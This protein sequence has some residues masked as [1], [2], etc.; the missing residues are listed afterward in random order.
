MLQDDFM[1]LPGPQLRRPYP[2]PLSAAVFVTVV[3]FIT[4]TLAASSVLAQVPGAMI[5]GDNVRGRVL[6]ANQQAASATLI[7]L[8]GGVA[9]EIPVGTGPHE[10]AISHDGHTGAISIYGIQPAGNQI[11]IIDMDKGVV[12]KTL[13]LGSYRRPHGMR[14]LPGDKT[15]LA[16]S[17]ASSKVLVI[18]IASGAIDTIP[19]NARGSHMMAMNDAGTVLF[20]ANVGSGSI[21][22]MDLKQHKLV[23]TYPIAQQTEGIS[24]SPDGRYV[25]VGSNTQGTVTVF[26]ATTKAIAAT[27]TDMG[28]PYRLAVAPDNQFTL[29]ANPDGD[30]L[31]VIDTRTFAKIGS[32]PLSG[33]P[34]G[35]FISPDSRVAFVTLNKSNEVAMVDIAGRKELKRFAVGT[36]PDGVAYTPV[37]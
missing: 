35:I 2:R 12:K 7:N 9:K 36:G 6:V 17:E 37:H 28:H 3:P 27:I 14:F 32:I 10:A 11:A 20:T 22:E 18:D 30:E 23:G 26:D 16:T 15:L 31:N 24:V 5:T 1:P 34:E 33:A 19:S 8:D 29:A 13:D 4:A 21:S 25:W